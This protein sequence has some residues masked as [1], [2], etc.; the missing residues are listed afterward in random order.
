MDKPIDLI[1]FLDDI[2][3]RNTESYQTDFRY[4][5]ERLK[6]AVHA[7]DPEDRTFYWMS[8]PHGT[9]CVLERDAFLRESDGHII[10]THYA[11]APAGIIA[12][13]VTVTGQ[14]DAGPVGEAVRLEYPAQAKRV[15]QKALPVSHVELTFLSGDQMTLPLAQ[16][17]G[18]REHLFHEY[19]MIRHFRYCPRDEAELAELIREERRAQ[20]RRPPQRKRSG[21]PPHRQPGRSR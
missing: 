4:D 10:W 11:D 20:E 9:W 6:D 14:G 7:A 3:Q 16:Y 21:P 19:G 8:R 2:V 1:P 17:R 13:R 12:Y 5:L 15:A 18:N